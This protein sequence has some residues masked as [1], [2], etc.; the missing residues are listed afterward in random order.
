M[1]LGWSANP[2]YTVNNQLGCVTLAAG[3]KYKYELTGNPDAMISIKSQKL[4]LTNKVFAELFPLF[5]SNP[6]TAEYICDKI[7]NS[8]KNYS[9][10]S[11]TKSTKESKRGKRKSSKQIFQKSSKGPKNSKGSKNEFNIETCVQMYNDLPDVTYSTDGMAYMDGDSQGCR[12]LHSFM[13]STNDVHCPHISFERE[14]DINGKYKCSESAFNL[15]SDYFSSE[16]LGFISY[17]G[18]NVYGFPTDSA[19]GIITN[20]ECPPGIR[21]ITLQGV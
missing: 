8:C 16:E 6:L 5:L 1:K 2:Y 9:I 7:V 18:Q 3:L 21:S 15:P 4:Y 14:V 17:V 20:E 11:T 12:V 10:N 19:D 13:A